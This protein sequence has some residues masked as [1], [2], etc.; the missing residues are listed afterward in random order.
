MGHVELYNVTLFN[1]HNDLLGNQWA[2]GY[3]FIGLMSVGVW[4]NRDMLIDDT[5]LWASYHSMGSTGDRLHQERVGKIC[6]RSS[7]C[8][9]GL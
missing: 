2:H 3:V 4:G 5:S 7:I 6:S 8:S 9:V 1:K